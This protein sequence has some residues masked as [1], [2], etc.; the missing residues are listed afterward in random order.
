MR[1][2]KIHIFQNTYDVI[3]WKQN[4]SILRDWNALIFAIFPIASEFFSVFIFFIRIRKSTEILNKLL[5][6]TR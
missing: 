1:S 2:R 6:I 5:F 3:K 4:P